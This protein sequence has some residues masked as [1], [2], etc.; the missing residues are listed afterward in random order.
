MS[1]K[2]RC[3]FARSYAIYLY[4]VALLACGRNAE[5]EILCRNDM[6]QLANL[7]FVLWTSG[8]AV[9]TDQGLMAD[10][11][12]VGLDSKVGVFKPERSRIRNG[13]VLDP[14]GHPYRIRY[15]KGIVT[16][17]SVGRDGIDD[18]GE[19]DDIKYSEQ[20]TD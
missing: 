9:K 16:L 18:E 1:I 20:V 2:P 4:F 8:Q 15:S 19:G 11:I 6:R 17:W 10:L 3:G 7:V 14:L 13:D 5:F 12:A